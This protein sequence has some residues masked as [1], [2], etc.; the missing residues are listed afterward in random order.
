MSD[1]DASSYMRQNTNT[2]KNRTLTFL[3]FFFI[4]R[5]LHQ[6]KLPFSNTEMQPRNFQVH[7]RIDDIGLY[8]NCS[9]FAMRLAELSEA[10]IIKTTVE[11]QPSTKELPKCGV[12]RL[13]AAMVAL[14]KDGDNLL[15]N[16]SAMN[17]SMPLKKFVGELAAGWSIIVM[18]NIPTRIK[19]AVKTYVIGW[20]KNEHS[21]FHHLQN[22]REETTSFYAWNANLDK[23]EVRWIRELIIKIFL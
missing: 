8:W 11:I 1:F 9:L 3:A 17:E 12:A 18:H 21:M 10:P 6:G 13:T 23:N 22:N 15:V 14:R 2:G 20:N 19:P 5:K 7:S 16:W 4:A